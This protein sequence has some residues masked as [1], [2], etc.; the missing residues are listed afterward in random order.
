MQPFNKILLVLGLI[1]A[2]SMVNAGPKTSLKNATD[3]NCTTDKAVQGLVMKSTIGIG[4][5]CGV[6][7]TARDVSGVDGKLD[8]AKDSKPK[9]KGLFSRKK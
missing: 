4:N 6:A 7:E 1:A 8:S 9:K 3:P 5:R 2:A